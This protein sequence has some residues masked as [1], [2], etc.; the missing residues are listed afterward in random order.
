MIVWGGD[1]GNFAVLNSGGKYTP[2]TDSWTTTSTTN[3]P[4]ARTGHTAV[5]SGNKMVVWGGLNISIGFFNTGG[6]Y[7][8][9]ADS[10][11]AIDY[12]RASSPS[13]SHRGLDWQ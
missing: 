1:I 9:A 8:P 13:V 6:R 10:W 4:D 5:G 11:T 3:A 12:Q 2:G 7:D